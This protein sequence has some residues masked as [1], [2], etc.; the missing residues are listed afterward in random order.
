MTYLI[1]NSDLKTGKDAYEIKRQVI[2][3]GVVVFVSF[4]LQVHLLK[5]RK[6]FTS[7]LCYF[8]VTEHT[9]Y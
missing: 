9:I 6:G 1:F 7:K 5:S 8:T 2:I 4:F 3:E